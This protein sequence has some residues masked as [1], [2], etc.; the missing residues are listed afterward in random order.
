MDIN[1]SINI[2]IALHADIYFDKH[3]IINIILH[4]DKH[5]S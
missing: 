3:V 4:L 1:R 5:I 2:S